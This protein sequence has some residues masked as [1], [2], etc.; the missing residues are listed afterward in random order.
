LRMPS[1]VSMFSAEGAVLSRFDA[2]PL[3]RIA[4]SHAW[5]SSITTGVAVPL[6]PT[7]V[8]AADAVYDSFARG[9]PIAEVQMWSEGLARHLFRCAIVSV[10]AGIAC[11]VMGLRDARR[12]GMSRTARFLGTAFCLLGGLGAWLTLRVVQGVAVVADCAACGEPRLVTRDVCEHCTVGWPARP[13][14]TTEIHQTAA[15]RDARAV[16][17][18]L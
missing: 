17:N 12:R 7:L 3:D 8:I 18:A 2:S 13:R 6:G 11:G 15:T 10:I 4:R 16:E 1:V 9:L 5:W 14:E